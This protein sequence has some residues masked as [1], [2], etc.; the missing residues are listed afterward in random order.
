MKRIFWTTAGLLAIT[1]L[2]SAGGYG[3]SGPIYFPYVVND[4]LTV[5]E[6]ILTNISGRDATVVLTAYLEDGTPLPPVSAAV[7]ARNQIVIS[8]PAGFRGWLAAVADVPGVLGHVRVSSPSRTA[9]DTTDSA[10][11]DTTLIFPI[12][13]QSS[14]GA[15]EIAVVNPSPNK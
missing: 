2:F 12:A 8:A 5:T 15:T 4:S 6:P 7:P 3:Q 1:L 9:Q 11:P 10:Q 13:A 14:A